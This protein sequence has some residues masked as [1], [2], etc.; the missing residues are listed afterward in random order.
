MKIGYRAVL[1]NPC[2]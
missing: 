2:V 1:G